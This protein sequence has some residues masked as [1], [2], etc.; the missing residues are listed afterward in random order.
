[1]SSNHN[2]LLEWEQEY[3]ASHRWGR[4]KQWFP[5]DQKIIDEEK[6]SQEHS[7][8]KTLWKKAQPLSQPDNSILRAIINLEICNWRLE[9]SILDLCKAIGAHKAPHLHYCFHYC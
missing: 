9:E 5:D 3:L 1:M 7:R 4:L 6:I 2:A 8:L